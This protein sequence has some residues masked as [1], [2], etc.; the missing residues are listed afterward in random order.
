MVLGFTREYMQNGDTSF[1]AL[2]DEKRPLFIDQE[3]DGLLESSPFLIEYIPEFHRYLDDYLNAEL[4]GVKRIKMV[5]VTIY[6]HF[7]KDGKW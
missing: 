3:F 2:I 6:T 7:C 5:T 4:P 1:G